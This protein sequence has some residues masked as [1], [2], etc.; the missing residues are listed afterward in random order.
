[1]V[2]LCW[3][4]FVFA[5]ILARPVKHLVGEFCNLRPL[6]LLIKHN[7]ALWRS[8]TFYQIVLCQYDLPSY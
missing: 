6:T 2:I 5:Y 7:K 8:V 4:F 1:M 3:G